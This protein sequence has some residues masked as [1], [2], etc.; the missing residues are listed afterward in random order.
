M[1]EVDL[2]KPLTLRDICENTVNGK[3][4]IEQYNIL[5]FTTSGTIDTSDYNVYEFS[6]SQLGG[7]TSTNMDVLRLVYT[8]TPFDQIG[9]LDNTQMKMH[10]YTEVA[11]SNGGT[12]H[13]VMTVEK[14]QLKS[15]RDFLG[16]QG[17]IKHV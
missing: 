2:T 9:A 5:I 11:N 14:I 7:D 3:K 10:R 16:N 15:K 17:I 13:N 12:L 1:A 6:H 8:T 4:L